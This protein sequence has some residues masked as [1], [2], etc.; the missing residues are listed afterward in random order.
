MNEYLD[1]PCEF[2]YLLGWIYGLPQRIVNKL[3][4]AK[5]MFW[6]RLYHKGTPLFDPDKYVSLS[7]RGIVKMIYVILFQTVSL[8]CGFAMKYC[9]EGFTILT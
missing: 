8:F 1:N 7:N 9:C 6:V 2:D 5:W 4:I 3:K